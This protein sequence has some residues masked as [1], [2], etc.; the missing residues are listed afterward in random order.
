MVVIFRNGV[1]QARLLFPKMWL[2]LLAWLVLPA[3]ANAQFNYTTNY[4]YTT[5]SG[6]ITTNGTIT[7]TGYTGPGGTAVI[8]CMTNGYP[9][10][11]IG[12]DAF[13][14]NTNLINVVIPNSILSISDSSFLGCYGLTGIEFGTNL[15]SIGNSTFEFCT[16]LT[17]VTIPDSVETIGDDSF[18]D[19][20]S[21]MFIQIGS[22]V[23]NLGD[24]PLV[25]GGHVTDDGALL[26]CTDL[27]AISVDT[28]NLFFSSLN[29]ALYDKNQTTLLQFPEGYTGNYTIPDSVTTIEPGAFANASLTNVTIG[30]GVTNI[31]GETTTFGT[32]TEYSN[33][34]FE[35][36]YNLIG[37]YFRGNAPE[38]SWVTFAGDN[39]TAYYLPGTSGWDA[40]SSNAEVQVALWLPQIQTADGNFGIQANQ[41]GFDTTWASG[42]TVIVQA[43]TNL[44][45]PV[46]S[47]IATNMLASSSFYF[48]DP[49]WTNYPDRFYRV[50]SQ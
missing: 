26:N 35:D 17:N 50:S 8:P 46:W 40:F 32:D 11:S 9:V 44:S 31:Q 24:E 13:V 23:T 42:Q 22:G 27:I 28:N 7:I 15:I 12:E 45:N 30:S 2:L 21:L 38:A 4:Y 19:C 39:V 34:P 18:S 25:Y 16:G 33:G 20:S 6:V 29:G 10:T 43:A 36:C 47:P 14:L 5:N 48:T 3:I 49:Q 1:R 41:F 37:V